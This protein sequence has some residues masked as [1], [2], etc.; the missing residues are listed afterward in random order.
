MKGVGTMC[1]RNTCLFVVNDDPRGTSLF[2]VEWR[3]PSTESSD[4]LPEMTESVLKMPL[5]TQFYFSRNSPSLAF[6]LLQIKRLPHQTTLPTY[7]FEFQ[8]VIPYPHSLSLGLVHLGG[9]AWFQSRPGLFNQPQLSALNIEKLES[10]HLF[11]SV[12]GL[13]QCLRIKHL[14]IDSVLQSTWLGMDSPL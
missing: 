7:I 3:A 2:T 14:A 11:W 13:C 5:D 1:L 8:E 12:C 9:R 10:F 4:F 6:P